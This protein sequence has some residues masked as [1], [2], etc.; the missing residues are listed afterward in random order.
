MGGQNAL[1]EAKKKE[2]HMNSGT[3]RINDQRSSKE[4]SRFLQSKRMEDETKCG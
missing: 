3:T 4:N 1:V 2:I